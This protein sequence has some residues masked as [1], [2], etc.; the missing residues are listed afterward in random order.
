MYTAHVLCK[1]HV[2]LL[3]QLQKILTFQTTWENRNLFRKIGRFPEGTVNGY[4]FLPREQKIASDNKE[5][6]KIK[7]LKNQDSIEFK[8][9]THKQKWKGHVTIAKI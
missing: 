1:I 6:T 3:Y 7:S 5:I 4:L 2:A 9:P 8:R